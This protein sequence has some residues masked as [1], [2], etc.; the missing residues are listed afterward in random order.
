MTKVI[1]I[2]REDLSKPGEQRVALTPEYMGWLCAQG[3]RGLVQPARHPETMECKRAFEDL[4]YI[5]A[6]AEVTEDLGAAELIVGLKEIDVD[7][8]LPNKAYL[9]FSHTH[10]GQVKNR[11]MLR[12]FQERHC[13]LIDYELL[14]KQDG[15]RLLTA[16]TYFA[17][18]AGMIDTLWAFGLRMEYL[19]VETLFSQ[20]HQS[21]QSGGLENVRYLLQETLAQQ[22]RTH[23]TSK[24]MPPVITCFLGRGKTSSGAQEIYDW[25]PCQ[26]ISLAELPGV[27]AHGK[28]DRV[29]KLVLEVYDM[30][31]LIDT[32]LSAAVGNTHEQK[33]R[34]YLEHPE[35]YT[36]NLDQVLPYIS[37]LMNCILWSPKYPRVLPTELLAELGER[38]ALQLIGDITCDPNGAIEFSHETWI[39]SPLFTFDAQSQSET[40]G[41]EAPGV[42]VM[43]VTNLPCEFPAEASLQFAD[44]L[45]PLLPELR[46]ARWQDSW[47]DVGFS[48]TLRNATLL[49]QGE[50]TPKYAYMK[51][52]LED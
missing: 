30:Y 52:F 31:R 46:D 15:Q 35:C 28:R 50:F 40:E 13:T 42:V 3:V 43:A 22:I 23:G 16:F 34:H 37:M 41:H 32:Q 36:S 17:G 20:M 10:K 38:S 2:R 9:L 25:L 39:D 14:C 24:E 8:I 6:G 47:E 12:A 51:K 44:E 11:A 4:D 7:A 26:E 48:E 33:F 49:W 29:Y 21:I 19:G 45:K 1:A 5:E 18:Y 27:F